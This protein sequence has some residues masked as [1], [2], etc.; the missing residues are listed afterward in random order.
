MEEPGSRYLQSCDTMVVFTGPPDHRR[1]IFAKNS[2]RPGLECQP[3]AQVPGGVHGPGSTVRCQYLTIPQAPH[4][5]A[6]LGSRPWWLWGF[7]HGVN[8]AGV[9]IG[10]EAIYTHDPVPETGLLGMDLVRLGLERGSTAAEAKN[11]ITRLLERH[12]QGGTAV[13][14]TD[15]RY[16]NSFLLADPTEAWVLETSGRNWVARRTTRGAVISNLVTIED[17]WDECSDGVEEHA[18]ELGY[19]NASSSTRFDFRAAYEDQESRVW[20]EQRYRV[21]CRLLAETG[22]PDLPRMMRYLRDHLAGGSVNGRAETGERTVCLHPSVVRQ[23]TGS[24]AASMAVELRADDLPPVAWASM[25]TPCTGVFLPVTVGQR[26]PRELETANERP[27]P[28]SAWWAMRELQ[29]VADRDPVLLAPIAQAAWAPI[30]QRLLA[31]DPRLT[32]ESL[33]QVI[34]E[35]MAQRDQLVRRLTVTQLESDHAHAAKAGA[36]VSAADA[37]SRDLLG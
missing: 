6:V 26:L 24:T 30:E 17:D 35:V 2:D 7:E 5:L 4:T 21:G 31:G 18:R 3:L 1:A 20:T 9:A 16:H 32:T 11:V 27:D 23:T 13:N 15:R 12:G 10:N 22:D 19:W 33:E 8:E 14:G 28:D 25:A 29:Y 37:E 36:T 34:A